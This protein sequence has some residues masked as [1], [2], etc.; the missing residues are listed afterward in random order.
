MHPNVA[1]VQA[2]LRSSGSAAEVLELPDST[3]T[4]AEAAVALGVALGQIAKSLVFLVDDEP[5]L[6]VLSGADRLDTERLRRHVGGAGV[7]RA[8]AAR[9]RDATGYPIGGVSPLGLPATLRLVLDTALADYPVVWAAA[10][11]PNA[12]FPTTYAELADIT[13]A[14]TADLREAPPDPGPPDD[15]AL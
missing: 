13:G 7:A 12:V 14:D 3:R 2:V 9:V 15:P 5:V 11:T 4:S 6:A 10:G 1:R 8:D